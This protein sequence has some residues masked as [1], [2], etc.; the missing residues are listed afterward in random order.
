MGIMRNYLL[1]E[2]KATYQNVK[3]TFGYITKN[4]RIQNNLLKSH[5]IDAFC[6]A[7]NIKA[8][9]LPYHFLQRQMRK[10]N[11]QIHK[12]NPSKKGIRKLNQA[13]YIVQGF[14]LF[15]KVLYNNIKCFVFG[16]RKSG[17]FD[18]RTLSGEIVHRS[19]KSK[20]LIL[21]SARRTLPMEV[22]WSDAIPPIP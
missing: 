1:K 21:L 2:L 20:E 7:G 13:P 14:R 8:A 10:H 19:A 15:D 18:L 22:K 3:N 4:T 11:R 5:R 9:R 16:R 17:Y 6:I 12:T